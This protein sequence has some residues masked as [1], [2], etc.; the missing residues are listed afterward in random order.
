MIRL[1]LFNNFFA[2]VFACSVTVFGTAE[3]FAAP[4]LGQPTGK[5]ILSI[6][7]NLTQTNAPGRADFDRPMLEA[8]GMETLVTTT[9]WN[10]GKQTFEGVSMKRIMDLIGAHGETIVG[11]ALN[12]YSSEIP[13]SELKKYNPIIALKRN[14]EYM[15]VRDKGPLWIVYPR[16]DYKELMK[17]EYDHRWIWQLK[18]LHVK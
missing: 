7:G 5:V 18:S 12:D 9:S 8:L 13:F 2:I 11:A 6:T 16:D 10:E 4:P 1:N 15:P 14:G 3:T 17:V